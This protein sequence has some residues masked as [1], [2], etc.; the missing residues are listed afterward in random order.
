QSAPESAVQI[1]PDCSVQ[2]APD[3][4]VQMGPDWPVQIAPGC[5]VQFGPEYSDR[6]CFIV[7]SF[8]GMSIGLIVDC[9]S[10]VLS[11]PDE[12]IAEKPEINTK[13]NCGYVQ[14]IGKIGDKVV[15]LI[16]CEKLFTDDDVEQINQEI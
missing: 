6:T 13:G 4:S 2:F 7:I 8:G 16:D 11:I 15:L 9:V 3:S 12:N 10:E 14:N 5:G 1:T